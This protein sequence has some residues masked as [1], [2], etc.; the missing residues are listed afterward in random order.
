MKKVISIVIISVLFSLAAFSQSADSTNCSC[1]ITI[2]S[3]FTIV[4]MTL[5]HGG[6]V[7]VPPYYQSN[8]AASQGIV[9]PFQFCFY[10]EPI[11]LTYISNN[12]IITFNNPIFPFIIQGGFPLGNDSL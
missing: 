6:D 3:T 9:L 8:N 10:D 7:G 11:N 4:P 2:D 12:G 1:I 5:G